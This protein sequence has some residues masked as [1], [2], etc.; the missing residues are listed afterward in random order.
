M[1]KQK[2][3]YPQFLDMSVTMSAAN[4]LT[5]SGVSLGLSVF[6]YAALIL[7]RI[8]FQPNKASWQELAAQADYIYLAVTGSNT[9][10]NLNTDQPEVFDYIQI[11]HHTVGTAGNYTLPMNPIVHDFGDFPGGGMLVPASQFYLGMFTGG[12]AAAGGGSVRCW[13][14]VITLQAADY[15]ELAQRLRV[16]GT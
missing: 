12:F 4:T 11:Y 3:I 14:R 8:E 5:F 7:N 9:L 10:V 13:Y 1:A 15:L 6:E 16:L 2:D